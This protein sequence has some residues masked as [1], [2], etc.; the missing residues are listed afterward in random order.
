MERR[1]RL[2]SAEKVK[3]LLDS[4]FASRYHDHATMLTLASTAVVLAEEKSHELPPDLVVTAWTVYGNALRITGRYQE[5]ERALERATALPASDTQ[6]KSNLLEVKAALYRN[7][8]R[9]ESAVQC[10]TA[11]LAT[12]EAVGDC[13]IQARTWNLLGI[14]YFDWG[15]R[16][17]ALHAYKTA[18]EL[19]GLDGSVEDLA[20]TGHNMLQTLIADG[21]L[22]AATSVLALLE[23]Y[24]RRVTSARLSA[25]V[26]WMR[27]RLCRG[28]QQLPA[29]QIAYERA[30]ALLSTEPRSPELAELLQEMAELEAN[31]GNSPVTS[32]PEANEE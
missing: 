3:E 15:D 16:E 13:Q 23:P 12:Y 14:T 9:F 2:A 8:G 17:Q 25:K 7:T 6:T 11:A 18:L 30:Y 28:L 27:A 20:M 19:V 10:L 22:S 1:R 24:Y 31:M 5:S 21:R 29:A 4:A 26:E 32:D